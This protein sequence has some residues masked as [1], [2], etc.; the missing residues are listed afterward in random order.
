MAESLKEKRSGLYEM[1]IF[2]EKEN[3]WGRG[4]RD[5]EANIRNRCFFTGEQ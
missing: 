5:K 4:R 2:D 3:I 1:I